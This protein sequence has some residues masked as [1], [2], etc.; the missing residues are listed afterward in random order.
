MM[1]APGGSRFGAAAGLTDRLVRSIPVGYWIA[2]L[3]IVGVSVLSSLILLGFGWKHPLPPPAGGSFPFVT[4]SLTIVF[5]IAIV[6]PLMLVVRRHPAPTRQLIADIQ[7]HKG[8][9]ATIALM[10]IVLPHTLDTATRFKQLIPQLVPFYADHAIANFERRL[11]GVDAWQIT[12]AVIGAEATRAIDLVYGLWHLVNIGLLCWMVL[13]RDRR[14]QIQAVLTYQ[15]AWLLLGGAAAI[16]LASV[17]PCFL[18]EFTGDARFA[19]LMAQLRAVNGPDGLHSLVA[20]KYLLANVDRNALGAGISAMPSLHVGIAVF[21]VLVV[22][23]QSRRVWPRTGAVAYA[24]VIY[25]GSVHLGWHYASDGIVGGVGVALI[26]MACGRFADLAC[27]SVLQDQEPE[28]RAGAGGPAGLRQ[29][30]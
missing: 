18:Q 16:A 29:R 17:G 25:V 14:F 27:A 3:T 1:L 21:A 5:V 11:L 20:M 23:R 19:P 6:R 24:A 28:A 30:S 7:R 2:Y 26:W 22:F 12:H 9:L 8:W 13:T 4:F 15:L 10:A